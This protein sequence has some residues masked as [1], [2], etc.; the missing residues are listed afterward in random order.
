MRVKKLKNNAIKIATTDILNLKSVSHYEKSNV[1]NKLL[2]EEL[3]ILKN[4]LNTL[5]SGNKT[6]FKCSDISKKSESDNK[7]SKMQLGDFFTPSS[8]S[9][10]RG[11]HQA[12]ESTATIPKKPAVETHNRFEILEMEETLEPPATS[13][14]ENATTQGPAP[15]GKPPPIV[16]HGKIDNHGATKLINELVKCDFYFNHTNNTTKLYIKTF[17]GWTRFVEGAEKQGL[18]YHTFTPKNNKNHTF[19]INGLD[20]DP[21]SEEVFAELKKKNIMVNKVTRMINTVRPKYIITTTKDVTIST[22]EKNA[23]FICHTKAKYERYINKNPITQCRRCQQHNHA[24]AN[25]KADARCL[26]CAGGHLTGDCDIAPRGQKINNPTCANCRGSH[27]ASSRDCP[28]YIDI[29]TKINKKAEEKNVNTPPRPITPP[30]TNIQHF[31]PPKPPKNPW[32]PQQTTPTN[33]NTQHTTK[34]QNTQDNHNTFQ[35]L[36]N[37]FSELNQ[38]IDIN[39]TLALVNS[40]N[41]KLKQCSTKKDKF[42]CYQQFIASLDNE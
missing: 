1:R 18:R 12:E 15:K 7:T 31:P 26:K 6:Q 10:K 16:L 42:I 34:T 4:E 32:K 28:K 21:A 35:E 37:A 2:K 41:L 24:T 8:S 27:I 30:P 11:R 36:N 19:V 9:K 3:K 25:C 20:T 23:Q 5:K 39:E 22:L 13:A 40:L 33:S 17:D 38:L 14:P 29:L